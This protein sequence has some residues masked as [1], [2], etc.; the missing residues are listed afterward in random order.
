MG[1]LIAALCVE[2]ERLGVA[3]HYGQRYRPADRPAAT[4]WQAI[5]YSGPLA[6]LCPQ[7]PLAHRG[8]YLIYLAFAV[9]E[10][11]PVDTYYAPEGRYWFGRVSVPSNFSAAQKAP[12]EIALCVEIPEGRWGSRYDFLGRLDALLAQL[13]Q[14][15]ILPPGLRPVAAQQH[16]LPAV[17]PIYRRGFTA[18]W[19]RSLASLAVAERLFPLGRQGLFLHCNIDHCVQMARDLADHLTNGGS[20]ADWLASADRYLTL[21]VRD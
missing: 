11:G 6:A 2:A 19:R 15:G 1:A 3:I 9:D 21:Q 10:L 4:E 18:T 14:A 8:L 20:S 13:R 12:G 5:V 16:Y 17:Y 7:A